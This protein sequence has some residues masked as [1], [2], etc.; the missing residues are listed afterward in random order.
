VSFSIIV[1]TFNEA[2]NIAALLERIGRNTEASE[3]EIIIVDDSTDDTARNARVA[4][5][6]LAQRVIVIERPIP[7]GGLSGA[8]IEGLR[9]ADGDWCVVMDGDLQHPPELLPTLLRTG[10][11]AGADIVVASRYRPGG[12]SA[13][14]QNAPRRFVSRA[15]TT[16]AKTLFPRRL[17]GCSDPMTGFFALRRASV[18][19]DDLHPLGFKILLE[20]LVRSRLRLVEVPFVFGV[21][22]GG[23]SKASLTQGLAFLRQLA[24]LRIGAAPKPSRDSSFTTTS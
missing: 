9:V 1:P 18:R 11:E 7:V 22:G 16:L 8:V 6:Q 5:E 13:G 23:E 15:S 20:I 12:D 2:T 21:R 4:A 17:A 24:G 19:P 3:T 10:I 14:L